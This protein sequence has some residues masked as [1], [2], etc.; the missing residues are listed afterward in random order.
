MVTDYATSHDG[1]EWTWHGTA[2][3]GRPGYWDSRGTRVTAVLHTGDSIVAYYDGRASAA[4]N[5]EERTGVATGTEPTALV[6]AG[7]RPAGRVALRGR[8]P[9]LP[10]H[11]A[12]R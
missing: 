3:N 7:D 2:L 11:P 5:Y 4:E 8:R 10:G 6:P 1:K 9:A 12:A